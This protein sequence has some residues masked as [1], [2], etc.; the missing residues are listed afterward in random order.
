MEEDTRV[1]RSLVLVGGLCDAAFQAGALEVWLDEAGIAFDHADASGGGCLNAA[2]WAQ[3]MD[4]AT[5]AD[6]WRGVDAGTFDFAWA[7][8]SDPLLADALFTLEG[9]RD[10]A[11]ATWGLDEGALRSSKRRATIRLY[12]L[13]RLRPVTIG[14]PDLDDDA[15][16]AA[17]SAPGWLPPVPFGGG[18]CVDA[19]FA[20]GGSLDEAIRRGAEE[21][22]IVAP[23]D[24]RRE[25]ALAG[26]LTGWAHLGEVSSIDRLRAWMD[27]IAEGNAA[28]EKGADSEFGRP[29]R[30]RLLAVGTP[31]GFP[32][33][34]DRDR[35]EE[36]VARGVERARVW[37][38]EQGVPLGR[39]GRPRASTPAE[40]EPVVRMREVLRG[41]LEGATNGTRHG[42]AGEAVECRLRVR[43]DDAGRI[44]TGEEVRGDVAGTIHASG[45]GEDRRIEEGSVTFHQGEHGRG[46][47]YRLPF[48]HGERRMRTLLIVRVPGGDADVDLL[49]AVHMEAHLL[50]GRVAAGGEASA[51]VVSG[52]TLVARALDRLRQILTMRAS[53]GPGEEREAVLA[54][55]GR[56]LHGDVW[57]ACVGRLRDRPGRPT[58]EPP[59][60]R[61]SG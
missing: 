46:V 43:I 5:I 35:V 10:G 57:E 45:L 1:R 38:R 18:A 56:H 28:L 12:D 39:K 61:V 4:G 49:E 51:H 23:A 36:L 26:V 34:L 17:I 3:G 14:T 40:G 25:Q 30:T 60:R 54:A 50:E 19:G 32:A 55:F 15:L 47:V 42:S 24:M 6:R 7:D 29:V 27:R 9:W 37:C 11:F 41:R 16:L 31:G 21:V 2:M 59:E 58:A 8:S 53:G 48:R 44:L 13:A 22:W 33:D 52:G 20:V